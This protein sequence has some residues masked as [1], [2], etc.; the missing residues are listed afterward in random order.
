MNGE[1]KKQNGQKG[2]GSIFGKSGLRGAKKYSSY[3]YKK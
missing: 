3:K 2:K 1:S